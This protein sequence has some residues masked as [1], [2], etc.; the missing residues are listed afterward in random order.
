M[1]MNLAVRAPAASA[2]GAAQIV[3]PDAELVIAAQ[4]DAREFVA[5]YERY[6]TRVFGYVCLRITD[7]AS[8]EDVTSHVFTMALAKLGSFRGR[9]PFAAWL[10]G[11]ARN[12]V[13]DEQRR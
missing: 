4:A 5:L 1:E 3:D 13:K 6:F 12:A 7:R 9:G 11:I 10:F 8:C 2:S